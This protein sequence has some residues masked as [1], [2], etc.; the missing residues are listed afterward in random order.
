[1]TMKQHILSFNIA[2]GALFLGLG[3]TCQ[4]NAGKVTPNPPVITDQAECAAACANLQ[5][6]HCVEGEPIVMGTSCQVNSD[7]RG[8][9][10]NPDPL[11]V[12]SAGLCTTSCTNFCIETENQGVWLDPKCVQ[13]ITSC[14]QINSCPMPLKP[15]PTCEGPMCPPDIRTK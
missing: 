13:S 2:A 10:G 4:N 8:L 14:D 3:A 1:M 5:R 6:L 12:C 7:C 15:G 9:D 11:Q